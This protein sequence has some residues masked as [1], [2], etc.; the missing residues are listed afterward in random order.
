MP[1]SPQAAPRCVHGD[2]GVFH[3]G[4]F[5]DME[6]LGKKGGWCPAGQAW[7]GDTRRPPPPP[8]SEGYDADVVIIGAGCVG[9]AIAR[10]LSK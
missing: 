1:G 6:D 10:E 5:V 8:L 2:G 7:S 9:S 3:A 4:A